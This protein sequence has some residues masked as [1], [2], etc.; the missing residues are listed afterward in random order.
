MNITNAV[1]IGSRGPSQHATSLVRGVGCIAIR[2]TV[3]RFWA[4]KFGSETDIA[5]A[6]HDT[7][8]YRF[9][10][11]QLVVEMTPNHV[12]LSSYSVYQNVGPQRAYKPSRMAPGLELLRSPGRDC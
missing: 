8:F 4:G 6:G 3:V 5:V 9:P 10:N 2:D 12:H 7:L 11:V 1:P